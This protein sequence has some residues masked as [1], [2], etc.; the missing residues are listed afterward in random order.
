M[1]KQMGKEERK[2]EETW[3]E[4]SLAFSFF[5]LLLLSFLVIWAQARHAQSQP[6]TDVQNITPKDP[7]PVP[8]AT[9][10][11]KSHWLIC[12]LS[13]QTLDLPC[14]SR[15]SSMMGI[16]FCLTETPPFALTLGIAWQCFYFIR[17]D[18]LIFTCGQ[19]VKQFILVCHW[20]V[21]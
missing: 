4:L 7:V 9:G 15:S 17:E 5:F 12:F 18:M 19:R 11:I 10:S 6:F 8:P 16:D 1:S 2:T 21:V 3:A 14:I 20:F 13:V